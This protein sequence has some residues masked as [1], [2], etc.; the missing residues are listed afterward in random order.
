MRPVLEVIRGR[1]HRQ[2]SSNHGACDIDISYEMWAT[3]DMG[4]FRVVDQ[5]ASYFGHYGGLTCCLPR[6]CDFAWYGW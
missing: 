5:H 2:S 3:L 1:C 6:P 4:L